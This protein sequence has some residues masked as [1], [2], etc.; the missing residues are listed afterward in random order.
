MIASIRKAL[1]EGD[2]PIK[3][4]HFSNKNNQGGAS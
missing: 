4:R 3:C 1:E 2:T